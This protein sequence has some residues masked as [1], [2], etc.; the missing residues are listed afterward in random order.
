MGVL[1]RLGVLVEDAGAVEL[2]QTRLVHFSGEI[3]SIIENS[4]SGHRWQNKCFLVHRAHLHSQLKEVA[5]SKLGEGC[6]VR[7]HT[8]HKIL[9]V[10][11]ESATISYENESTVSGDVIVGADGVHSI[12][13]LAVPSDNVRPFKTKHSALRFLVSKEA[14]LA[15]PITREFAEIDGATTLW[16]AA[17]R[18]VVCYPCAA[19]KLLNFVC[20]HPSHLSDA[21]NDYNKA[22]SKAKLLEIYDNFEPT[23]QHLLAM[24]NEETL[25][26][27]PLFD[28]ETLPSFCNERLAV[29]GDA[30][31]P[32]TPHLAQ[33]AAMAIEDAVSLATMLPRGTASS[34]V[35]ARLGLYNQA[36]Y[37]RATTIQGYSR[38]VG[39]DG[40]A[41][42]GQAT[43]FK[44]LYPRP[45]AH[46]YKLKV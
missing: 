17:D 36:R 12:C 37:Q 26:V 5:T 9:S 7:I 24:A 11:P 2:K 42:P 6:P 18:K 34:E 10:E 33:G 13:R 16:Y 3:L 14:A 31:H 25:S 39:S 21:S 15:D 29:I 35:T 28:M 4:K 1:Q 32:F 19:N 43:N 40:A 44:G 23:V 41:K 38:L 8:S 27:Y 22:G 45:F 30:A 46:Y 20:I